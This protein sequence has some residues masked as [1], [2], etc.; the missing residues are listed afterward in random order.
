MTNWVVYQAVDR[1]VYR[2]GDW[3]VYQAVDRALYR[4]VGGAVYNAVYQALYT[5]VAPHKEP[6]QPGLGL[7]LGGVG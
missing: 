6:P 5:A 4:A 7:Y 2:A 3:A 1:V